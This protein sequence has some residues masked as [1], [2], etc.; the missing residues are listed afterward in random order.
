MNYGLIGEHLTHSYSKIIH[1]LFLPDYKYEIHELPPEDLNQFLRE[2]NFKGINVTIPY[3]KDV[4]PFLDMIDFSAKEVGA[5][6]TIVNKNG[7]LIGS[8]TDYYGFEYVLKKNK[9]KVYN[10]KILIL[11]NGGA[12]NAVEAVLKKNGAK[13]ILKTSRFKKINTYLLEDIY[14]HHTDCEIIINA[15]PCGM[16]PHVSSSPINLSYFKKCNAVVDCI[17]NPLNTLFLQQAKEL[18]IPTIANG[19]LML[20]A[21]AKKAIEIFKEITIVDAEIDRIYKQLLNQTLNLITFDLEKDKINVL[22]KYSHKNILDIHTEDWLKK[23]LKKNQIINLSPSTFSKYKLVL[24]SNGY[25]SDK[26]KINDIL[27]DYHSYIESCTS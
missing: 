18:N 21:Q 27:N 5:V 16:Y 26:K 10:K 2:K 15:T 17:Y 1:E 12:S 13:Q 14:Q 25:I 7:K 24:L 6:N 19:L 4:I 8:N 23:V 11:G 9:I 20:I 3:K 22:A